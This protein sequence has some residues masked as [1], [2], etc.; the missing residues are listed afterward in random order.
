MTVIKQNKALVFSLLISSLVALSYFAADI[1]LPALPTLK[2]V[3]STNASGIQ[4]TVSVYL[5]GMVVAQLLAGAFAE[6]LGFKKVLLWLMFLFVLATVG[7]LFSTQL[8]MLYLSRFLQALGAG[9][10]AVIGRASFF[11]FLP[12]EQAARLFMAILPIV[13]SSSPA[14]AP[15]I[16]GMLTH[17]F[18]WHSVFIFL[19]VASLL[20]IFGIAQMYPATKPE[21]ELQL[22]TVM[23]HYWQVISHRTNLAHSLMVSCLFALYYSYMVEVPFIFHAHHYSLRQIGFSSFGLAT[24]FLVMSQVNSRLANRVPDRLLFALGFG[25]IFIS[26]LLLLLQGLFTSVWLIP[27]AL[28]STLYAA[29]IAFVNPLAVTQV[30]S[31]MPEHTGYASSLIGAIALMGAALGA[32]IVHFFAQGSLT[33]LSLYML[34]LASLSLLAMFLGSTEKDKDEH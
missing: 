16:G 10:M 5:F 11:K 18:G 22:S 23:R 28:A 29:G 21:H 2:Q 15:S 12:K 1:Y 13:N 6:A 14:I 4:L 7:C 17:H 33:R 30:I 20:A 32:K 25:L 3:F 26:V 31:R 19:F 9:G 8:W 24:A 27:V 34:T